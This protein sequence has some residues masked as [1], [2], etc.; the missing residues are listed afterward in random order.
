MAHFA[1]DFSPKERVG[2]GY[3][4]RASLAH[5]SP[6]PAPVGLRGVW[7]VAARCC[8]GTSERSFLHVQAQTRS[9]C[10]LYGNNSSVQGAQGATMG[11]LDRLTDGREIV[12]WECTDQFDLGD[13]VS[14]QL[15]LSV[16]A[17]HG[18]STECGAGNDGQ[19]HL[20]LC[21]HDTSPLCRLNQTVRS[22]AGSARDRATLRT[23]VMRETEKSGR[24]LRACARRRHNG[25]P[26]ARTENSAHPVSRAAL[27]KFNTILCL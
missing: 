19:H 11:R 6:P 16:Q 12:G 24:S 4:Q 22:L 21:I 5:S 3:G 15:G 18:R 2:G 23:L 27:Y 14:F 9:G 25:H 20:G 1:L 8:A 7:V 13:A 26:F 17:L 10:S